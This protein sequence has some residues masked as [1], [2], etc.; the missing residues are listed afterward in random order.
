MALETCGMCSLAVGN[1]EIRRT[2]LVTGRAIGSGVNTVA[3]PYAEPAAGW[4]LSVASATVTH[5]TRPE[6][7]PRVMA[8]ST[9]VLQIL[10]LR[11]GD[12]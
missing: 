3:E 4:K 7:S 5:S 6:R 12:G 10:V 8:G 9:A 2:L 11:N 1:R